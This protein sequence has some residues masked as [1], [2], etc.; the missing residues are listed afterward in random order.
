M[1]I[2]V[3]IGS[4]SL[5]ACSS[6]PEAVG[7]VGSES[8]PVALVIPLAPVSSDLYT[9]PSCATPT[10]AMVAD[11][12]AQEEQILASTVRLEFHGPRG[13]IGHATVVGGRFLIT[14]NHYPITGEALARGADGLV[15]AVSIRKTNGD[16]VLL[17]APLSFFSVAMIAPET[18]VLDFHTY[19]GT[20]FFDSVGVPSVDVRSYVALD[21]QPGS[22]MAQIDW[23][24]ATSFVRWVQ[25]TAVMTMGE[26]PVVELD[27][28]IEQ[29]AS[30]GGV[31][32]K[33]THIAN[34][35]SRRTDRD[36]VTG[37][38]LRQYSVA[39]M[40]PGTIIAATMNVAEVA[41]L[42]N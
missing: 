11:C 15:T 21:L 10:P 8:Q 19:G 31:F 36:A 25:V 18:L 39:A 28:Y 14:H 29:G 22:T 13:G 42:G 37:E 12:R 17:K 2:L 6:T 32:Y 26:T 3:G 30:G 7:L 20:G 40:N 41:S 34:N 23:D 27:S 35:E 24:G 16:I 4:V 9:I 5:I 33:G 1:I 38:M